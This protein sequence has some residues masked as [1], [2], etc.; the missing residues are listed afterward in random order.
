MSEHEPELDY[1]RKDVHPRR[2]LSAGLLVAFTA[3]GSCV[4]VL[5]L[6]NFLSE[7]A[8]RADAPV[9][10]LGR[11]EQGQTPPEPRLQ[12]LPFK[13]IQEQRAEERAL[14]ESAAWV[15][16]KAGLVRIPVAEALDIVA[17]QGLPR[18]PP[19]PA[20]SPSAVPA[21]ARG[22]AR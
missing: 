15:D 11:H 12:V 6:F 14:L 5:L 13:D 18:W 17:R 22:G 10:A 1:E 7:R 8:R 9:A 4:V 19:A 20:A 3:A 21:P 2:V 16:R